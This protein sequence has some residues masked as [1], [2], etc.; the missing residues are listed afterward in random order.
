MNLRQLIIGL[1]AVLILVAGFFISN[2]L[3][4]KKNEPIS[5]PST[6]YVPTVETVSVLNQSMR[7]PITVTGNTI[8]KEAIDILAEVQGRAVYAKKEFRSAMPFKSGE[9]L[10]RID[11][12]EYELSVQA[13]RSRLVTLANSMLA[14]M[15]QVDASW[16]P[17]W[18]SF[19]DQLDPEQVL[20]VW[21][22]M[23]DAREKRFVASRGLT[24]LY[25]S[26]RAMEERLEKY[27]LYAPFDGVL[28]NSTISKGALVRPGQLLGRFVGSNRYE[29]K[30]SVPLQDASIVSIG[31]KVIL[32]DA[33]TGR[34][35][36]GL[37]DRV[38]NIVDPATQSVE[39]YVALNA[40]DLREGMFM[41]GEVM[42]N[43]Q[44][45]AFSIARTLLMDNRYVYGI[46]EGKLK[47]FEVQVLRLFNDQALVKGLD[48]GTEIV[49]GTVAGAFD[50]MPVNLSK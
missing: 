14:D 33:A 43:V 11:D 27:A 42:A 44:Q 1:I 24:E 30:T 4:S 40:A 37:V 2:F 7:M 46:N 17:R 49:T 8:A 6:A 20:P 5:V 32:N 12:P 48:N 41:E 21:P 31:D 45:E 38:T 47:R 28:T 10:L 26:T 16:M 36:E 3:A 34:S 13:Q 50:G 29:V 18:E 15:R 25:F 35:Y 19:V 23:Q 22:E 9:L 39:L